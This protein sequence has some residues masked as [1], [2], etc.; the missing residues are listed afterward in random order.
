MNSRLTLHHA[1]AFHLDR[2]S[3]GNRH[4]CDARNPLFPISGRSSI[5][6][7]RPNARATCG[8]SASSFKQVATDNDGTYRASRTI[9]RINSQGGKSKIWTLAELM[10][11]RGVS[12]DVLKC[13]PISRQA[14]PPDQWGNGTS[15]FEQK[16]QVTVVS[17]YEGESASPR[18]DGFGFRRRAVCRRV[19][20][21]A[22]GLRGEVVKFSH[23]GKQQHAQP[24]LRTVVCARS[25]S[26][27]EMRTPRM[28]FVPR[29]SQ[30]PGACLRQSTRPSAPKSTASQPALFGEQPAGSGSR[31]GPKARSSS[32][33]PFRAA[34][35]IFRQVE[36]VM[37][38]ARHCG[39]C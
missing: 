15:Y 22:H 36:L 20:A 9:R 26:P 18:R 5:K 27:G 4:H 34:F 29:S 25:S 1:K 35:E 33:L 30:L 11:T 6:F 17:A 23:V 38:F 16:D 14:E 13:P 12:I 2:A 8:R 31:R 19:G 37:N 28:S 10:K 3:R 32:S 7:R 24:L 21:S 39:R